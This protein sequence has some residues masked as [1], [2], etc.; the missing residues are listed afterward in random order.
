MLWL[1]SLASKAPFV[2]RTQVWLSSVHPTE[3][4][5]PLCRTSTFACIGFTQKCWN[6]TFSS[7]IWYLTH[8]RVRKLNLGSPLK[9]LDERCAL[10]CKLLFFL[11]FNR[12]L[13]WNALYWTSEFELLTNEEKLVLHRLY[14][15]YFQP[16][17][18]CM[19]KSHPHKHWRW[20]NMWVFWWSS[21]QVFSK[22]FKNMFPPVKKMLSFKGIFKNNNS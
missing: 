3:H 21:T 20:Q 19:P 14:L 13:C 17:G 15:P 4:H 10:W 18:F 12:K 2:L 1:Q 22:K 16:A 9:S 6:K 8:K 11:L 5:S 7:P